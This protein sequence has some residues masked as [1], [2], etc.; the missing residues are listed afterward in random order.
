MRNLKLLQ[1]P[2]AKTCKPDYIVYIKM[3]ITPIKIF[4]IIKI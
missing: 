4:S 1:V 2:P 3:Q